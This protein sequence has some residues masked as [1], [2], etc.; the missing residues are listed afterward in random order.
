[1]MLQQNP[2]NRPSTDKLLKSS[3]LLKKASELNILKTEEVNAH[4]LKTIKIPKKI[5]YLTDRLPKSNY[6]SIKSSDGIY[7]ERRST[8]KN[9]DSKERQNTLPK[10]DGILRYH[11]DLIRKKDREAY[12][13]GSK[14]PKNNSL[15]I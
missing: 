13:G 5:H 14:R 1:M 9:A 2:A 12:R 11:E 7:K 6:D 8:E 10:L 15:Q 3:L 4:L